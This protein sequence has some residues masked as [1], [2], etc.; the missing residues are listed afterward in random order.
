MEKTLKA[1]ESVTRVDKS[2]SMELKIFCT[3]KRKS[4]SLQNGTKSLPVT[5][6]L[7]TMPTELTNSKQ[8]NY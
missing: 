4:V 6:L 3:A 8:P 2:E 5:Y 1:L 7:G